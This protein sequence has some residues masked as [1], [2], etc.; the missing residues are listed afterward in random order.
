MPVSRPC[1]GVMPVPPT[2][3]AE[4]SQNEFKDT[5]LSKAPPSNCGWKV[6][7]V[8]KREYIVRKK[9]SQNLTD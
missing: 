6:Y 7:D 9:K 5:C 2:V 1:L 8:F 3:E 4:Y